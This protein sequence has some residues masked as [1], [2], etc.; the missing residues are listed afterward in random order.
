MQVVVG[1]AWYLACFW[2]IED[3]SVAILCIE[4]ELTVS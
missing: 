4:M 3:E 2:Y 1:S